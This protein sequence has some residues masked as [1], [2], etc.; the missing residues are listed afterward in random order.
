VICTD[1]G[2]NRGAYSG[3]VKKLLLV[4]AWPTVLSLKEARMQ[5]MKKVYRNAKSYA[6]IMKN[7][8]DM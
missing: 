1:A 6:K 2:E 8:L 7:A 4:T 5:R 3:Y